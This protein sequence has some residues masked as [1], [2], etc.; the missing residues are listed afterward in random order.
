MKV[1]FEFDDALLGNLGQI[2]PLHGVAVLNFLEDGVEKQIT[3]GFGEPTSI[4]A[5]GLALFGYKIAEQQLMDGVETS[6]E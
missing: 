6:G 5:V 4:Q 3:G 2:L 1:E